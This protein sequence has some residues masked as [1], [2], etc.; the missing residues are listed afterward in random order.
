MKSGLPT[1][2]NLFCHT[3]VAGSLIL[4]P[5]T[6]HAVRFNLGELEG[7]FD[8]DIRVGASWRVSDIDPQN[9]SPGN[10]P[11]GEAQSSTND[12]G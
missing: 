7:S 5:A 6:S 11:G 1:G 2:K 10:F 4:L 12:D 3:L 9:V 8:S